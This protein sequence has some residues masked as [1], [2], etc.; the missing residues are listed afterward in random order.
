M[1]SDMQTMFSEQIIKESIEPIYLRPAAILV[2]N[3]NPKNIKGF[4]DLS[5]PRTKV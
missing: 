3:G 1:M 5:K 2:R 4:Q